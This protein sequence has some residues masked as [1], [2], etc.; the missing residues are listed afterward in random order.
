MPIDMGIALF[1]EA[2]FTYKLG[3]GGK[4]VEE[5]GRRGRQEQQADNTSFLLRVRLAVVFLRLVC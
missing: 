5:R 1:R 3:I 2:E 4:R